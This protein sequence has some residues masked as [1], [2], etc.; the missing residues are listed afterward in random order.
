[1]CYQA[2]R[3]PVL[4][5]Y[6]KTLS[7]VF[8]I[9]IP[10]SAIALVG[11]LVMGNYKMDMSQGAPVAATAAKKPADIER[12][13]TPDAGDDD[14]DEEVREK[15]NHDAPPLDARHNKS[16]SPPPVATEGSSTA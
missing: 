15:E 9:G 2:L 5:A 14:D 8:V 11:A 6:M 7:A 12:G 13:S 10:A 1:M 16:S 3:P 4:K